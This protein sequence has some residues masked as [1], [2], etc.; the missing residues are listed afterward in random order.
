LLSLI[1]RHRRRRRPPWKLLGQMAFKVLQ[2]IMKGPFL[3]FFLTHRRPAQD[4]ALDRAD[5]V[6]DH[7]FGPSHLPMRVLGVGNP[8]FDR[9]GAA[10]G[11]C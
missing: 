5:V 8:V 9:R 3:E 4:E 2:K 6:I 11:A 10:F 1:S 7:T